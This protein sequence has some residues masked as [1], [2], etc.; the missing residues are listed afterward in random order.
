MMTQVEFVLADGRVCPSCLQTKCV[1]TVGPG[2][3]YTGQ[4]KWKPRTCAKCNAQWTELA[5]QAPCYLS[6]TK[7]HWHYQNAYQII[8]YSNFQKG[9]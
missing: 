1:F 4:A 7:S 8:G 3:Q 6:Q 5:H 9:A 2:G